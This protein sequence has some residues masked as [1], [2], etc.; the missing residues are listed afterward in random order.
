MFVA[1][2]SMF[3]SIHL[4]ALLECHNDIALLDLLP[5]G[6]TTASCLG[7]H[8]RRGGLNVCASNIFAMKAPGFKGLIG[9]NETPTPSKLCIEDLLMH[10]IAMKQ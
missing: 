10:Y 7:K 6:S 1:V 5:F 8:L 3:Y 4:V 2:L 9:A